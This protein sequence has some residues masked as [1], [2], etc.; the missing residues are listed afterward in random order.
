VC[1]KV[2][3]VLIISRTCSDNVLNHCSLELAVL[4]KTTELAAIA[5]HNYLV[6]N[7]SQCKL[8]PPPTQKLAVFTSQHC[9]IKIAGMCKYLFFVSGPV[10]M[11]PA[12]RKRLNMAVRRVCLAL[13]IFLIIRLLINNCWLSNDISELK[14]VTFLTTQTST[15]SKDDVFYQSQPLTQSSDVTHAVRVVKNV[16]CLSSLLLK[17]D[18]CLGISDHHKTLVYRNLANK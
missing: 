16:T 13:H 1:S 12:R 10:Y 6:Y 18:V 15:G 14:Q 17:K 7:T 11:I 9:I 3:I 5:P 2:K 4:L 8:P